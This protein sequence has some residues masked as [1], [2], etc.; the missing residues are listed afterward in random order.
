MTKH[1][2]SFNDGGPAFPCEIGGDPATDH[3]QTGNYTWQRYGMTLLD[4]FAG[5]AMKASTPF[6]HIGC[7]DVEMERYTTHYY[8]VAAAMLK[9]R[10]AS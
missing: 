10:A 8:R 3:H 4:Y 1:E 5:E 2:T 6:I 7:T 9:A